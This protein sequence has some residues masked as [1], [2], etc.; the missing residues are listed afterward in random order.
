[1]KSEVVDMSDV[2]AVEQGKKAKAKKSK[3]TAEDA[4]EFTQSLG[5]VVGGSWRQIAL[6]KRMGVPEAL[7]LSTEQWVHD[8]LGGYVKFATDEDMQAA[9]KELKEKEG[10]SN[11][12]VADV[13]GVSEATV[14][15]RIDASNDAREDENANDDNGGDD[16]SASNDAY[17]GVVEEMPPIED[18][19]GSGCDGPSGVVV[20]MPPLPKPPAEAMPPEPAPVDA[21]AALAASEAIENHVLKT[22]KREEQTDKRQQIGET[23]QKPAELE[24]IPNIAHADPTRQYSNS[25]VLDAAEDHSSTMPSDNKRI[26]PDRAEKHEALRRLLKERRQRAEMTQHEL[27]ARMGQYKSFVTAVETGQHRVTVLELIDFAKA[28]E[29]DP[30]AVIRRVARIGQY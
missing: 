9:I 10:L 17:A 22:R 28:L 25:G 5:Q 8:R 15:R 23:Q 7:G 18:L 26:E 3:I 27:A 19:A 29:F 13:I 11:R 24:G 14:R 16:E 20:E 1:M 30:C 6:A 2:V 4:E 21:I 12:E